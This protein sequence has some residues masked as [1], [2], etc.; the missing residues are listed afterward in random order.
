MQNLESE[1][2]QHYVELRIVIS[3][4]VNTQRNNQQGKRGRVKKYK[5]N[6]KKG[7]NVV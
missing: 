4:I 6:G 7:K 5:S 1:R 2:E 3:V